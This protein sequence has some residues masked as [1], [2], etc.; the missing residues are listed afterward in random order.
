MEFTKEN[1]L[2]QI[3]KG[4]LESLENALLGTSY[5]ELEEDINEL[6]TNFPEIQEEMDKRVNKKINGLNAKKSKKNNLY[7]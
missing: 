4:A 6:L 3:K 1:K 7:L 2:E 5:E